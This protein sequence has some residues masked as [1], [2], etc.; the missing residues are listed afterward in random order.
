F[1]TVIDVNGTLS[2]TGN[3]T[4]SNSLRIGAVAGDNVTVNINPGG[5]VLHNSTNNRIEIGQGGEGTVNVQGGTLQTINGGAILVGASGTKGTVNLTSGTVT[6][7][8][9]IVVGNVAQG[10][11]NISGGAASVT[12]AAGQRLVVAANGAATVTVSGSGSLSIA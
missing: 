11:L 1:G 2:R 9:D 3:G 6:S 10:V 7:I 5:T 8:G 4:G 12:G